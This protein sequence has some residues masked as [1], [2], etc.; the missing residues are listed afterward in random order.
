MANYI[1]E[2]YGSLDTYT[3]KS[4]SAWTAVSTIP[5]PPL[6]PISAPGGRDLG[7]FLASARASDIH[8]SISM[9]N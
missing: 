9:T 7:V 5:C 4:S 3:K 6:A 2:P 1:D 8:N